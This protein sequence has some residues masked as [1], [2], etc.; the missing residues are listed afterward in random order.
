L[1]GPPVPVLALAD[2][3]IVLKALAAIGR[4]GAEWHATRFANH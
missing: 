1:A 3:P 2:L 4:N